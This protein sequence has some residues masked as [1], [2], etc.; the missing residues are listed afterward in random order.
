MKI[1]G[2]LAYGWNR[3]CGKSKFDPKAHKQLFLVYDSN[4]SAYL[5]EHIETRELPPAR[6]VVLNEK[7]VFGFFNELRHEEGDPLFGANFDDED[8]GGVIQNN[9]SVDNKEEGPEIEITSIVLADEESSVS[10]E[11]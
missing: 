10:S 3:K 2:G 1:S 5:K 7:E 6:T 9:V 11:T 4:I 8:E